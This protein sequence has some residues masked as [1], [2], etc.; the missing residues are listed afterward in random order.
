MDY[1][2]IST[3]TK[4]EHSGEKSFHLEGSLIKR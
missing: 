4:R 2:M 3:S 1:W